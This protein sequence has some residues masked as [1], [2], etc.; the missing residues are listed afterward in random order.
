[1]YTK[2][3][4]PHDYNNILQHG[5]V[6]TD[7]V[8]TGLKKAYQITR[9]NHDLRITLSSNYPEISTKTGDT[10][11]EIEYEIVYAQANVGPW[12][13]TCY[14]VQRGPTTLAVKGTTTFEVPKCIESGKGVRDK[15][16]QYLYEYVYLVVKGIERSQTTVLNYTENR[17]VITAK[18]T[19]LRRIFELQPGQFSPDVNPDLV[20]SF[21]QKEVWLLR[22]DP[23][24]LYTQMLTIKFRAHPRAGRR[25]TLR[26]RDPRGYDFL[27]DDDNY[28]DLSG[29]NCKKNFVV[30]TFTCLPTDANKGIEVLFII[31]F[32]DRDGVFL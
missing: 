28:R 4:N 19:P 17:F 20:S 7:Y 30:E 27:C 10:L 32:V 14:R 31:F 2:V 15:D 18:N 1:V 23:G 29:T 16:F 24:R 5:S 13:N 22:F 26:L 21:G 25:A 9:E 6:R 3:W 12:C 11:P 8:F